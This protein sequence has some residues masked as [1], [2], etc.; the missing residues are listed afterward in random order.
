MKSEYETLSLASLREVAK[1]KGFK[2]ISTLRKSELLALLIESDS[3]ESGI[4]K[5]DNIAS[6][7]V[8]KQENLNEQNST[9]NIINQDLKTSTLA[10]ERTENRLDIDTEKY[11]SDKMEHK[12]NTI[13]ESS[14]R[15]SYSKEASKENV[16]KE[17]GAKDKVDVI[18]AQEK[19]DYRVENRPVD[20]QSEH[21]TAERTSGHKS[22]EKNDARGGM[23]TVVRYADLYPWRLRKRKE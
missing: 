21:R 12:G 3:M 11:N 22:E 6:N 5:K 7:Y 9:S 17:Y 2:G 14:Q 10:K 16:R 19:R 13:K 18:Q 8:Q 15:E 1:N 4:E 20:N 23:A